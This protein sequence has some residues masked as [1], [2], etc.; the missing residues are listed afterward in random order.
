MIEIKKISK[1][2][3]DIKALDDVSFKVNQGELISL[4]GPN[5]AGK[6]T[7]IRIMCGYL[8]P[9]AGEVLINGKKLGDNLVESLKE[10][11]YMPEG[12]PLYQE[13]KVFEYLQFVAS[14][15]GLKKDEFENNLKEVVERLEISSVMKQKIQTLSKG[16]KRRVGVASVIIHKPKILILDEPAEGLDPNQKISIRAFLREY[17]KDN[18]VLVST[19][20]LEEA[21]AISSRVLVLN[22]GKLVEDTTIDKLKSKA[23][24]KN[25][26][27]IFYKITKG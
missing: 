20:V 15:Y 18:I 8:L 22:N 1:E 24:D 4:L 25:L 27:E 26:S 9:N 21:E 17:A 10:I 16:F 5:G 11:G 19:H 3:A 14:I 13:M 12:V 6:S 7:L 2:F 23:S